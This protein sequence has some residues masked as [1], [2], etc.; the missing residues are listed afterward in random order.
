MKRDYNDIQTYY[1]DRAPVYDQIYSYPERQQDYRFLENFI[2]GQMQGLDVLEVAAGT[3]YWTQFIVEKAK[4]V[5]ATDITIE[6]LDQINTRP[7][8]TQ[9]S[10]KVLDAFNLYDLPL[11]FTAAFAGL[12]IS[13]V[14]KQKLNDFLVSLHYCLT[15]GARI[16]FLDNSAVQ[17]KALP[18]TDIDKWGNTYQNREL[19]DN[20]VYRVLKNFPSKQELFNATIEF[21]VGQE[22]IELEHFWVLTYTSR[23]K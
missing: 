12:W 2:P 10:T 6:A 13:H 23:L 19:E 9:V 5:L 21:G 3:G 14:P 22:Y 16:I 1:R 8:K 18:I 7:L 15:P 20:S 17:C 11:K 4:S